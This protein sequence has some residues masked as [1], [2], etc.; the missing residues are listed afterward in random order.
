[1]PNSNSPY[2]YSRLLQEL[3]GDDA[4]PTLNPFASS[5]AQDVQ[6][7]EKTP[8]WPGGTGLEPS[9]VKDGRDLSYP[10]SAGNV[11]RL[12]QQADMLEQEA[13]RRRIRQD[14]LHKMRRDYESQ[15][16]IFNSPAGQLH[17]IVA[18]ISRRMMG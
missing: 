16:L 3:W 6:Y 4:R 15:P 2:L 8:A 13:E 5:A 10:P 17:P 12:M 11:T 14:Q 9:P 1:M 7:D 18:E